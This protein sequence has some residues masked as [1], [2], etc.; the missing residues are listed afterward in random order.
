LYVFTFLYTRLCILLL[1]NGNEKE[2][3]VFR[4]TILRQSDS[5]KHPHPK[6]IR[7]NPPPPH[8]I[9]YSCGRRGRRRA[10]S[11]GSRAEKGEHEVCGKKDKRKSP[12][13]RRIRARA[14]NAFYCISLVVFRG[15][16]EKVHRRRWTRKKWQGR[17][18]DAYPHSHPKNLNT[19]T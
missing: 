10:R 5:T 13:T 16:R 18:A 3:H 4:P 6:M 11:Y 17:E 15:R 7:T 2:N 19:Q 14:V 8:V 1:R 9:R 12:S